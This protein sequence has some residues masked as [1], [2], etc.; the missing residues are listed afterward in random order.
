MSDKEKQEWKLEPIG[1]EIM[2]NWNDIKTKLP[3]ENTRV[4]IKLIS[5]LNNRR[6]VCDIGYRRETQNTVEMEYIFDAPV[7]GFISQLEFEIVEW[8]PYE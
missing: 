2:E 7:V 5:K 8:R 1:S 3:P 4:I 6:F